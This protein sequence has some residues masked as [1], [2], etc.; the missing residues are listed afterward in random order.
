MEGDPNAT[1]ASQVLTWRPMAD[2]Q[3]VAKQV[4]TALVLAVIHRESGGDPDAFNVEAKV[5]D[6]SFGLMQIL[7]QTSRKLGFQGV[8]R[9][10]FE[11]A[12]NIELGT[13]YLRDLLRKRGDV[14][15]ALIE[16]NGGP[17]AVT[18]YLKGWRLGPAVHY[19]NV[20]NRLYLYYQQ[21]LQMG[22]GQP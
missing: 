7:L 9:M 2:A 20:V 22:G 5:N 12:V 21:R 6:A 16:Y 13:R 10:L 18:L 3:A 1:I 4:P 8:P 15:L 17:V 14:Y 19:A 11:P